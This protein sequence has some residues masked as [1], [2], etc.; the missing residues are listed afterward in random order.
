MIGDSSIACLARD[1]LARSTSSESYKASVKVL[2]R[3]EVL[4]EAQLGKELLP[5]TCD[6]LQYPFLACCW[7]EGLRF[8]LVSRKRLPPRPCHM[9]LSRGSSQH[10]SLLFQS[11]QGRDR[12][13]VILDMVRRLTY[14]NFFNIYLF[15]RDTE[16]ERESEQGRGRDKG[17]HRIRSRLQALSCQH[18]AQHRARSYEP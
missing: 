11:Q 13:L 8:L 4:S 7:F 10:G 6:C 17:R 15:L 3:A 14:F 9:V 12:L 16:R 1:G 18:R 2:A 5:N